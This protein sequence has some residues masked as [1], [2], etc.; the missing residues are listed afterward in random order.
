MSYATNTGMFVGDS[1]I[2]Y[3]FD[4]Y[5]QANIIRLENDG[6]NGGGLS[7]SAPDPDIQDRLATLIAAKLSTTDFVLITAA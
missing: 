2:G 5:I 3:G 7:A 6:T 1:L 4:E